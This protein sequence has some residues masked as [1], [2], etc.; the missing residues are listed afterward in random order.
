MST[1][2]TDTGHSS[3]TPQV[4]HAEGK[5]RNTMGKQQRSMSTSKMFSLAC[6]DRCPPQQ[7]YNSAHR[8]DSDVRCGLLRSC[9]F[10][11]K[12]ELP[13]PWWVQNKSHFIQELVWD[14]ILTITTFLAQVSMSC[15][16]LNEFCEPK[17]GWNRL[18]LAN[19]CPFLRQPCNASVNACC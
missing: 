11:M 3:K 12:V 14:S 18:L 9:D 2:T 5:Q 19:H 16:S 15:A 8:S 6:D 4:Q 1:E 7:G 10:A 13:M 17:H